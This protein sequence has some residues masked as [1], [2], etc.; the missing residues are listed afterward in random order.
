MPR[1]SRTPW[2]AIDSLASTLEIPVNL[3]T[4]TYFKCLD[5]VNSIW[6]QLMSVSQ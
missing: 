3:L 4:N 5:E 1:R 6:N 2:G